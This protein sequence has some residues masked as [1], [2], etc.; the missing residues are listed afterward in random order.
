MTRRLG[1]TAVATLSLGLVFAMALT[2]CAPK[3]DTAGDGGSG[4]VAK[5]GTLSYYIGEPAYID[6][7]NTQESE[8]TQVEQALFDSLT[9]FD[10]LDA[11]K[12]VPAA[13]DSWEPNADASVWTF[14]LNKDAKF[15]DGTPVM[16]KDFVYAWNRIANPATKNTST[17]EADP[18]VVSYHIDK[19]KGFDEVT[20]GT[21]TEMSGLKAVDDYTLEV[22]LK[23]SFA[24]F[25]YV[26]A[27]PALAP[28]PQKAVEEGVDYNGEMLPY[29]DFPIGNG[30][31]KMSEPWKRG[32][33][34]KVVQNEN[35][36]GEA[37]NVD[38]IDFRIFKDPNT[39]YTEFEA[40]TLDFCQIGE[41]KI[42]DAISKYG[43]SENGYTANPG[44][45][46]LLG[47]ET[48]VYYIVANTK[49]DVMKDANIRKAVSY[50]INRQAICD[51]VFE[52]TREPADNIVP[53]GVA[54][55]EP[56]V[57]AEAKYDVEAAKKVLADAGY[58]DGVGA[59]ELTLT[60]NND[61]GHEKIMQLV[62]SDLKVIGLT[63]KFD[64]ADFP[65]TLKKYDAG[66]FQFGRLGWIADY[67]IMDNFLYPLFFSTAGDNKSAYN[68]PDVDKQ[69]DE[70]RKTVDGDA[71]IA[72]YQEIDKTIGADLPVIPVM[73]YKHHH[74]AS[75]RVHDLTYSA[76]G[77]ADFQKVWLE[78]AAK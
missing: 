8:G 49:N 7:Y 18:S 22:T 36:G 12:I 44:A 17:G 4:D 62:Q 51:V 13:A 40:G 42:T 59:P 48:A 73:F 66:N 33:Y 30:P 20:A 26:V 5:G 47:A 1:R 25:E 60:F 45:Q 41:G 43:E 38:G 54:G 67:P 34:I 29:G 70:A 71:R 61:G 27:H 37:A 10:A 74:I 19:V 78:A 3:T 31:F 58:P 68:N 63:V 23:E 64:T 56:G 6:P 35:Y 72:M 50:A 11:V 2:G 77:L 46:S 57:W 9:A 28:V 65:T 53:P 32:Q 15:S 76:M 14:K 52:G 55:Y 16:A 39:A 75:D 69:L 24:D 21:A